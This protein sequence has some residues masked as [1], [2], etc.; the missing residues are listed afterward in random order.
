LEDGDGELQRV[1]GSNLVLT[2]SSSGDYRILTR[3]KDVPIELIVTDS[4]VIIACEKWNRGD[5]YWGV[6]LGATSAMISNTI[7]KAKEARQ[8]RGTMLLGHIRYGWLVNVGYTI[9]QG[10]GQRPCVRFELFHRVPP[11]NHER[12]LRLELGLRKRTDSAEVAKA[13]TR[14]A[15]KY[16]LRHYQDNLADSRDKY[17]KLAAG[18]PDLPTPK[19]KHYAFYVIPRS[20]PASELTALPNT[21]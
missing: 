10:L 17:Q 13:I 5:R 6:G 3:L 21:D 9:P 14:R 12:R 20:F 11:D 8:R 19:P 16:W 18:P 4:R 7:N 15:A 2:A 1:E